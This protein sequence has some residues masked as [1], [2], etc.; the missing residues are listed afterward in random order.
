[1]LLLLLPL[2]TSLDSTSHLNGKISLKV[3]VALKILYFVKLL[4]NVIFC[5][6]NFHKTANSITLHKIAIT[7]PYILLLLPHKTTTCNVTVCLLSHST[8]S[9][10]YF[11]KVYSSAIMKLLNPKANALFLFL[12][13][14]FVDLICCFFCLFLFKLQSVFCR[15]P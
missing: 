1:M 14:F 10:V 6:P 13:F 8:L 12:L 7:W 4:Q 3:C 11:S 5:A 9:V 2:C 15:L